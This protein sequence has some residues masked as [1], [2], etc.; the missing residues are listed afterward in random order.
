V[1]IAERNAAVPVPLASA[2][3]VSVFVEAPN[4]LRRILGMWD[5]VLIIV[6]TVIGSGI[7]LVPGAVLRAVGNSVPTA[8][9]VW[10][11]GGILSLLGAL[12]YGELSAMKPRAGG[13]Y[14]Y[15]RDCYGAFPGFLFGWTVFVVI[16]S[17]SVAT[18]AV[19]FS[20]YLGEFV[21]LSRPGSKSIAV[22]MILV[23][24]A[25]N[26]LGTRKSA[27]LLNVTTTIKV[28]A[29]LLVSALLLWRGEHS[30]FGHTNPDVHQASGVAGF[31]V[32][33]I[34][35]LW[36]YEGWQ[37]ATYCAGEA[38]NPQKTFPLSFLIG[39]MALIAIYLLANLGY[40]VALGP[41]GVA[42]STRV[43]AT[44][45][46]A[47]VSHGAGKIV[48]VAILVSMFSAANSIMLNAPRVCYAM[49]K[50]GLFFKSLSQVHPKFGTPALAICAAGV[51]SAVLAATGTFEQ[52]LTCVVF[53]GWIFYALAAASIFTY[54]KRVPNAMRPYRVPAYPLTPILFIAAA[55]ALVANTV[56][57]QP[58]RAAIGLGIVFLGAPAYMLWRRSASLAQEKGTADV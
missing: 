6:G 50:D 19:A 5:L 22:L 23:I 30:A 25:V 32:A 9:G 8:L 21:Q 57:T 2:P 13:L 55:L 37:Y 38:V 3:A 54:R 36:A 53:V 58:V 52:L 26:V 33:M 10:L 1:T 7:F 29:I 17:G 31:G 20:N 46:G 14:V 41:S 48:A 39:T 24:T 40:L 42:D 35:V 56:V 44:S 51:W 15:I 16:G 45:L 18:L 11:A 12:T 47:V 34:S 28:G 4:Q 49:S 43:A 27:N